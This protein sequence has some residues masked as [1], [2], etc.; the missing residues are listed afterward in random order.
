VNSADNGALR[1][2]YVGVFFENLFA[3]ILGLRL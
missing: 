1:R 3:V 2:L